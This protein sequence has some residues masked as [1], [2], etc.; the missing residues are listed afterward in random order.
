MART[1]SPEASASDSRLIII[2]AAPSPFPNPDALVSYEKHLP[3]G[4]SVLRVRSA[5]DRR[6]LPVKGDG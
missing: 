2:Q 5:Y 3:S 1:V 6:L 4:D